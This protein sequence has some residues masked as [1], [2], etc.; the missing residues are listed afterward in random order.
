VWGVHG[1]PDVLTGHGAARQRAEQHTAVDAE[2]LPG[3]DP[4]GQGVIAAR[5]EAAC[6]R[7]VAFAVQHA[8]AVLAQVDVGARRATTSLTLSPERV[9]RGKGAIPDHA[10]GPGRARADQRPHFPAV[11]TSA[12]YFRPLF[13]GPGRAA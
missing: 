11:R 10:R 3:I 7:F 8:D 4:A 2:R 9:Q 12:G 13:G 5:V 1:V 6:G